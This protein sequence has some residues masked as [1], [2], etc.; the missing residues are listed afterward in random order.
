MKDFEDI[1]RDWENRRESREHEGAKKS[2]K[3]PAQHPMYH[4][5]DRY[6]P[7][8]QTKREKERAEARSRSAG[9]SAGR[10]LP[11][12]EVVDLHGLTRQEALK[13]C[14]EAVRRNAAG[15]E[16]RRVLIIHGKGL[17]SRGNE[18][19][20]D[21][22]RRFLRDHPLV[23]ETGVPPARDGGDGAVWAVCRR[24]GR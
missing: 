3:D 5:L 23:G 12:S 2:E 16:R 21:A 7:S 18:R 8:G 24:R 11:V 17:H 14:D 4:A 9:V 19:L 15:S 1:L 13:A 20:R 10:R 6:P 22:V